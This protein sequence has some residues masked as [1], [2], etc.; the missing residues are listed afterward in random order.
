M[1]VLKPQKDPNQTS[2][3]YNHQLYCHAISHYNYSKL[4]K[5]LYY[6]III[7]VLYLHVLYRFLYINLKSI[8]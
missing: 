8:I 5:Q 3:Y 2:R 7:T 6:R 4:P 1:P